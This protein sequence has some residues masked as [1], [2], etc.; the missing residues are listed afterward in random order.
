MEENEGVDDEND[1]GSYPFMEESAYVIER[2]R[3]LP[4]SRK[5]SVSN[6]K[7]F[8][9]EQLKLMEEMEKDMKKERE[10]QKNPV[11][12]Y[13]L[14]LTSNGTCMTKMKI[15]DIIFRYQVSN[16]NMSSGQQTFG[17]SMRINP[18]SYSE[19]TRDSHPFSNKPGK[20]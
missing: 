13:C 15:N 8:R 3:Q 1:K 6:S 12:A 14:S 19:R 18:L 20:I 5:N 16:I 10:Q 2:K 7:L 9:I 11:Q 4:L 17:M